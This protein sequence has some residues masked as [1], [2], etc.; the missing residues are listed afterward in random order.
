MAAFD[1][2]AA[3]RRLP[4]ALMVAASASILAA[5]HLLRS[6]RRHN[7]KPRLCL[8]LTALLVPPRSPRPLCT[9]CHPMTPAGPTS[10]TRP[11]PSLPCSPPFGKLPRGQ[12]RA[13][14]RRRVAG[15]PATEEERRQQ[16][17]AAAEA[18]LAVVGVATGGASSCGGTHSGGREN[19]MGAVSAAAGTR[20]DRRAG[21][22]DMEQGNSMGVPAGATE[23]SVEGGVGGQAVRG[24]A[25]GSGGWRYPRLTPYGQAL[26][27]KK[28]IDELEEDVKAWHAASTGTSQHTAAATTSQESSLVEGLG[29]AELDCSEVQSHHSRAEHEEDAETQREKLLT[30]MSGAAMALA[31]IEPDI[32]VA[33]IRRDQNARLSRLNEMLGR[34]T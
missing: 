21:S 13:A 27:L 22:A 12:P 34:A 9:P 6:L 25:V 18:R 20:G 19:G 26:L 17:A 5:A 33:P 16:R 8:A 31:S 23:G 7:G 14:N 32:S 24:E 28:E 15:R 29:E 3:P 30:R 10:S 1:D 4:V 2:K 11:S